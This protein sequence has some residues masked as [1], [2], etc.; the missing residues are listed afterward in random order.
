MP[1]GPRTRLNVK[2]TSGQSGRDFCLPLEIFLGPSVRDWWHAEHSGMFA[3]VLSVDARSP[4]LM[5]IHMPVCLQHDVVASSNSQ[6]FAQHYSKTCWRS[7]RE[8]G[9]F[10]PATTYQAA[11]AKRGAMLR[12]S[13]KA[14]CS[15]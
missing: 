7:S 5:I 2:L 6:S 3:R 1:F 10:F 4:F 11:G 8:M 9:K 15:Q 13:L 12:M 14:I